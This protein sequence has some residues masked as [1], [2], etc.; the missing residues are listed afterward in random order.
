M[1]KLVKMATIENEKKNQKVLPL[2][3]LDNSSFLLFQG[4]TVHDT[5]KV[6]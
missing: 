6:Y 1:P 5:K 4:Q 3:F 2:K